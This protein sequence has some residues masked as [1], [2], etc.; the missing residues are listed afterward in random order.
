MFLKRWNFFYV[1]CCYCDFCHLTDLFYGHRMFK[2]PYEF[3]EELLGKVVWTKNSL[4][5]MVKLQRIINQEQKVFCFFEGFP[6]LKYF[7]LIPI[8]FFLLISYMWYHLKYLDIWLLNY[9]SPVFV[10]DQAETQVNYRRVMGDRVKGSSLCLTRIRCPLL[11][12]GCPSSLFGGVSFLAPL[13]VLMFLRDLLGTRAF[14]GS[15]LPGA[16]IEVFIITETVIRFVAGM[17][18]LGKKS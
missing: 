15:S 16:N 17:L 11:T 14:I 6:F 4:E 12:C 7:L 1:S 13:T 10:E 18:W 9:S 2:A 8:L 3:E 5:A